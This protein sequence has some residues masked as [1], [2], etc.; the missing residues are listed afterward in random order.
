MAREL[1]SS[2]DTWRYENKMQERNMAH[3]LMKTIE[4]FPMELQ[5]SNHFNNL[6]EPLS[7]LLQM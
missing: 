3:F 1:I 6:R 5:T 7:W 4:A 2:F